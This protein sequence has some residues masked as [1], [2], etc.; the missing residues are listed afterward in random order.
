MDDDRKKLLLIAGG[1]MI[2]LLVL[3]SILLRVRSG[4]GSETQ[5][6]EVRPEAVRLPDQKILETG[7]DDDY[8]IDEDLLYEAEEFMDLLMQAAPTQISEIQGAGEIKGMAE[9][10]AIASVLSV[11]DFRKNVI[12]DDATRQK[13]TSAGEKVDG[14]EDSYIKTRLLEVLRKAEEEFDLR[15]AQGWTINPPDETEGE[16]QDP[17]RQADSPA[18]P[19]QDERA[20]ETG[21]PPV[22]VPARSRT[23]VNSAGSA[24]QTTVEPGGTDRS[25]SGTVSDPPSGS[26]PGAA[27][28]E[29]VSSEALAETV[30][31]PHVSNQKKVSMVELDN[32][33]P[34]DILTED[35]KHVIDQ[36]EAALRENPDDDLVLDDNGFA[37]MDVMTILQAQN[38]ILFPYLPNQLSAEQQ[39]GKLIF[40]GMAQAKTLFEKNM[41]LKAEAGRIADEL[42]S[43]D[44]TE[45]EAVIAIN[46]FVCAY[47]SLDENS[48]QTAGGDDATANALE[49]RAASCRGYA[50]LFKHMCNAVGI[51]CRLDFGT[52]EDDPQGHVW[53]YVKVDGSWYYCDSVWN[54]GGTDEYPYMFAVDL[55]ESR[56]R[57]YPTW[58][59]SESDVQ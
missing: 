13:L 51:D 33:Y 16:R 53:D 26:N 35:E 38:D 24:S 56:C 18:M 21:T 6:T 11:W 14:L 30:L 49:D 40:T 52:I 32:R 3:I 5:E 17:D 44:M 25:V 45:K 4:D 39:D 23:E 59:F 27:A 9:R 37:F 19:A 43:R 15:Q 47:L 58:G 7:G 42:I 12:R 2:G 55:W 34:Y 41:E 46:N 50:N 36:L 22:S 48:G 10:E 20:P 28:E 1:V 54:D 8:G 29:D 31:Y 57:K